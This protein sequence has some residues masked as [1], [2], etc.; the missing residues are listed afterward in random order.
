M[1]SGERFSNQNV[2]N[3]FFIECR[4]ILENME[5]DFLQVEKGEQGEELLNSIFRGAHTI[6]GSA[7]MF[8]FEDIES[9]THIMENLLDDVRK[10]QISIDSE[11]VSLLLECNDFILSMLDFFENQ[12]NES[13]DAALTEKSHQL[14][15]RLNRYFPSKEEDIN[16]VMNQCW[17]ISLRFGRDVYR[18]GLDPQSFISY[19]NK[20]GKIINIITIK[21]KIPSLKN[22]NPSDCYLGFEIDVK[23]DVKKDELEDVFDFIMDD[24]EIRILPPKSN[25]IEYVKL[26]QELP[27]EPARIGDILKKV[28]TLTEVELNRALDLQVDEVVIEKDEFVK[29]IGEILVD[30]QIVQ[31][32]IID[33]A[34][35][36]QESI[37]KIHDKN[38]KTIRVDAEKLDNLI[39][40]VGELVINS[41]NVTQLSLETSNSELIESV[42]EMSR[43]IEDIRD[44]TMNV[45]MVQI[46]ETFRKYERVV[47]DLCRERNKEVEFVMSGGDTELDKTLIEKIS[48]PLTHLVRNAIDHG[49]SSSEERA[50]MGKSPKGTIKLNAFHETG[51]IVIEVIDD[52]G[53]L[54]SERIYEKAVE[55]GIIQQGQS[56]SDNELFQLIFEPG[57]STAEKVTNIS[58]RG[59]GMDVVKRN[60]ESLR[61][62]VILKS[63]KGIGTTVRIH[64]PLT[65]A[66]IDGFLVQVGSFSYVLPL[67]MVVECTEIS[68]DDMKE[69]EGGNFINMRGEVLP[70][71]RLREYFDEKSEDPEREN[72]VVVEYAQKKAGFVVDKPHGEF[73]T[74]V[75]P[76]SKIFKDLKW[77]SGSTI[78]GNGQVA[79]ILDVP[80]LV[81][82]LQAARKES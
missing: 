56:L 68:K 52:G 67:D 5:S 42:S 59:V 14:L 49:I 45:R 22:Y 21:D 51:S 37:K 80:R 32:P 50:A 78:L 48:D 24:C 69:K 73:Q 74:V 11:M 29:P 75:K 13:L 72:I 66:I 61:G 47:R 19:L 20:I 30:T 81:Q 2:M 23:A 4:E 17:H 44:S 28:G 31:K 38:K 3:T 77:I 9:F 58:G 18:N 12:E 35:E 16:R 27:E 82:D 63:E 64:L 79:L 8:G 7:G 55:K 65:L 26:I 33:A 54:D 34:I 53:G 25:I 62:T 57:F 39:N 36:K 15:K 10:G 6:K 41:A 46:G 60:I 1:S 40:L 70:F 71:M 43:L 76:M